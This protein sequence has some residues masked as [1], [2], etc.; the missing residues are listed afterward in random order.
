MNIPEHV[1]ENA[2]KAAR[3][4]GSEILKDE[5]HFADMKSAEEAITDYETK[6]MQAALWAAF[7]SLWQPIESEM[8]PEGVWVLGCWDDFYPDDAPPVICCLWN[9]SEWEGEQPWPVIEPTRWAPIPPLP[10]GA[11]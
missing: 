8:P 3:Q 4:A 1:I 9:G 7:A 10:R 2:I 11:E 6:I 5:P